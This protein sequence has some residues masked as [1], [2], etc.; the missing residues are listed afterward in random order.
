M[1]EKGLD[2]ENNNT[3]YKFSQKLFSIY[4]EFNQNISYYNGIDLFEWF[5]KAGYEC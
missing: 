5:E 3:M 1:K 2:I 4:N